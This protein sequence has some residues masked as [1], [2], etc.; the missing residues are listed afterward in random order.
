MYFL[1]KK[2]SLPRRTSDR[3]LRPKKGSW[4]DQK[5]ILCTVLQAL[6]T[7]RCQGVGVNNSKNTKFRGPIT[8]F[9]D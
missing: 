8:G 7:L 5:R 4:I 3:K 2:K 6:P 9:L 1:E